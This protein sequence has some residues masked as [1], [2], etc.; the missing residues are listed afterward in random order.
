[1]FFVDSTYLCWFYGQYVPILVADMYLSS[2]DIYHSD[3]VRMPTQH[4]VP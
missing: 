3:T 4:H 1:M 2:S